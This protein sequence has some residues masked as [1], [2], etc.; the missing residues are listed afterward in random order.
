VQEEEEEVGGLV[1]IFGDYSQ[2]M[3]LDDNM[4]EIPTVRL[5]AN[6]VAGTHSTIN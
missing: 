6:W 1:S 3:A 2:A 4:W 5:D